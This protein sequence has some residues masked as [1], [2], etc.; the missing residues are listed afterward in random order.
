MKSLKK[1]GS[2]EKRCKLK[3]IAY[4]CKSSMQDVTTSKCHNVDIFFN[5]LGIISH[6]D[7]SSIVSR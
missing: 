1:I 6:H 4:T 7:Y 3:V 2:E 5:D